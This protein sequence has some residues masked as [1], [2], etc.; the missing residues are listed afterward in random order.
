M[1]EAQAKNLGV[2]GMKTPKVE[3]ARSEVSNA[4]GSMDDDGGGSEG[5]WTSPGSK[6]SE[7]DLFAGIPVG[8]REF[9]ATE[10]RIRERKKTKQSNTQ[11]TLR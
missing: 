9:M 10:K 11:S 2:S 7:D 8:I 5:L 3:I 6:G 1:K 4:S